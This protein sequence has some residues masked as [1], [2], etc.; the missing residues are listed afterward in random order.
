MK[1]DLIFMLLFTSLVLLVFAG[2]TSQVQ[3]ARAHAFGL[4]HTHAHTH[5]GGI[6]HV[7]E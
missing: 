1:R 3:H 6:T 5:A 2:N 7:H 4:S